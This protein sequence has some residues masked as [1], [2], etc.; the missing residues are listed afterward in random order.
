MK[1]IRMIVLAALLSLMLCGCDSWMDGSYQ[2]V[3]PHQQADYFAQIGAVLGITENSAK[4]V[5]FRAKKK[6]LEGY[7]SETEL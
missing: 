7:K 5:Y 2:S 1:K 4:I 3:K 6:M